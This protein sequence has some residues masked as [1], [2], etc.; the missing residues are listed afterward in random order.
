MTLEHVVAQF[1]WTPIIQGFV[2]GVVTLVGLFYYVNHTKDEL[3][4]KL[5]KAKE[6]IKGEISNLRTEFNTHV[7]IAK[8]YMTRFDELSKKDV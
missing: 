3:C 1:D 5:A 4:E 2:T 8:F 6:E 7:E